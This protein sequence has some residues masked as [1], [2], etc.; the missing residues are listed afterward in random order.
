[1]TLI[2]STNLQNLNDFEMSALF[3]TDIIHWSMLQWYPLTTLLIACICREITHTGVVTP[4]LE[5]FVVDMHCSHPRPWP[6]RD[7]C[8]S[9]FSD[10]WQGNPKTKVILQRKIY[11]NELASSVSVYIY[12]VYMWHFHI[13]I[14]VC[15]CAIEELNN[16]R[17]FVFSRMVP[18]L[19]LATMSPVVTCLTDAAWNGR[20]TKGPSELMLYCVNITSGGNRIAC[21]IATLTYNNY[22]Y[23]FKLH[24]DVCCCC[25]VT[26][27]PQGL[28]GEHTV[29]GPHMFSGEFATPKR[30]VPIDICQWLYQ[31]LSQK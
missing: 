3:A 16:R 4:K 24:K 11:S 13:Y 30:I 17:D 27:A 29:T 22:N 26:D 18:M 20:F 5:T 8:V 9:S 25:R 31:K 12:I 19:I 14:Y 15:V 21:A 28:S 1:M 10:D 2:P 6:H 7:I 23:A